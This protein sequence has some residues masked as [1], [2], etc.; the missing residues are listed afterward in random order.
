MIPSC[1]TGAVCSI[2]AMV[3][4]RYSVRDL[5][6]SDLTCFHFSMYAAKFSSA[7]KTSQT[8]QH[9][10]LDSDFHTV[11]PLASFYSSSYLENLQNSLLFIY[12]GAHNAER[13]LL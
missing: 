5:V 8:H 9:R 2:G 11:V 10:F 4:N 6:L 13:W 12:C 7:R 3:P 1:F